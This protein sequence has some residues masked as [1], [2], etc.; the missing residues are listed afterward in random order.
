MVPVQISQAAA[1]ERPLLAALAH[2]DGFIYVDVRVRRCLGSICVLLKPSPARQPPYWIDNF[3]P[4]TLRLYQKD[5][6]K[7]IMYL[8]SYQGMPYSWETPLADASKNAL[9]VEVEGSSPLLLG[10]YTLDRV[11]DHKSIIKDG[12][13]MLHVSVRCDGPTLTLTI[14][15]AQ[16]H[17]RHAS[18]A[19][20]YV[21]EA[22]RPEASAPPPA[23]S[24][25]SSSSSSAHALSSAAAPR[26]SA[27][28]QGRGGRG[29]PKA[30]GWALAVDRWLAQVDL[31]AVGIGLSL[32][33]SEKQREVLYVWLGAEPSVAFSDKQEVC[34]KATA[35]LAVSLWNRRLEQGLQLS[36][37][38]L[39]IDNLTAG[40]S[41]PVVLCRS[42]GSR[43]SSYVAGAEVKDILSVTVAR[44]SLAASSIQV[45]RLV[46]I[47]CDQL[48]L[49]LDGALVVDLTS[50]IHTMSCSIS[51]VS[52]RL[53]KRLQTADAQADTALRLGSED[54]ELKKALHGEGNDSWLA[55]KMYVHEARLSTLKLVLNYSPSVVA[56]DF[57]SLRSVQDLMA[58]VAAAA[59]KVEDV[60]VV[61][62]ELLLLDTFGSGSSI[63]DAIKR[64]YVQQWLVVISRSLGSLNI[65]GNPLGLVTSLYSGVTDVFKEPAKQ[66]Q[67]G[68]RA[69]RQ[70]L[71]QMGQDLARGLERGS[72][73]LLRHSVLG[74]SNTI[75][76]A[77]SS[78][79]RFIAYLSM[80]DIFA[81]EISKAAEDRE[82]PHQIGLMPGLIVGIGSLARFPALAASIL[83][84]PLYSEF[85]VVKILGH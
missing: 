51:P 19:F 59:T 42:R 37:R 38:C 52:R 34:E 5:V 33:D 81:S 2:Q 24:Y 27:I 40:A 75:S 46:D 61:L 58:G 18:D 26:H 4:Y 9:V 56:F 23:S 39:Q 78:A 44:T 79:A 17:P 30:S 16:L 63:L 31:T 1:G 14:T 66:L 50:L 22:R 45:F 82:E 43:V 70:S 7:R 60:P 6:S 54:R 84:S 13:A 3:S 25:S 20:V 71:V 73:S 21:A 36:I 28:V 67:S 48:D 8:R 76:K 47:A 62:N 65:L 11:G 77:S 74:W 85:Y 80:D 68:R 10:T 83:K 41:C 29:L 49:A 12:H 72:L 64:H 15:D 69:G 53:L 32:V 57:S 35:G 55:R